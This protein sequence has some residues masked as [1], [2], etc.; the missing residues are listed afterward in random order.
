MLSAFA[1]SSTYPQ[2]N[3]YPNGTVFEFK[4]K[5]TFELKK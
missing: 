2:H 1:G 4:A 5:V 3:A